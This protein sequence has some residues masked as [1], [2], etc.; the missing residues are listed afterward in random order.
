MQADRI[1]LDAM[2]SVRTAVY[3][4]EMIIR[5]YFYM[6]AYFLFAALL[7]HLFEIS[8]NYSEALQRVQEKSEILQRVI[9][10]VLHPIRGVFTTFKQ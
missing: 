6:L 10:L 8:F 5:F 9:E 2:T 7:S 4:L 1:V 3:T